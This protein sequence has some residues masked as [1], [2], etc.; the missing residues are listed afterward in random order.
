[1]Y[2]L[3]KYYMDRDMSEEDALAEADVV[4]QTVPQAKKSKKRP[5]AQLSK[6]FLTKLRE[7]RSK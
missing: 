2:Q 6:V 1:M 3:I 5:I 7:L 4:F